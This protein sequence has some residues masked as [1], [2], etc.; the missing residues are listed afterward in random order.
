MKGILHQ[1][2]VITIA[3]YNVECW[4]LT[5]AD[6]K[7][8]KSFEASTLKTILRAHGR[9]SQDEARTGWNKGSEKMLFKT[10]EEQR[11]YLDVPDILELARW[12]RV[13]TW[14]PFV[15]DEEHEDVHTRNTIMRQREIA[16]PWWT[17][18]QA[19]EQRVKDELGGLTKKQKRKRA[20]QIR[21]MFGIDVNAV[22]ET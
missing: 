10:R 8:L 18:F 3:L 2:L 17:S 6:V 12:R 1:V 7:L 11:A 21:D 14:K 20:K 19:D 13:A 5:K 22:V 4:N 16:S 9:V 15:G